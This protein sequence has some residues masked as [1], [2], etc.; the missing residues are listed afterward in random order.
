MT[1]FLTG[2]A[3]LVGLLKKRASIGADKYIYLLYGVFL[4]FFSNV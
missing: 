4:L 1:F 2:L 3:G